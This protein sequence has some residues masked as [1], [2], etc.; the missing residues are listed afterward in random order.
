VSRILLRR[1][2]DLSPTAWVTTQTVV[3]QVIGLA[4]FAVQAPLL[5]PTAFGLFSFVMV[6]VGFCELVLN[7]GV[8]DALISIRSIEARHFEVVTTITALFSLLLGVLVFATA[9]QLADFCGQPTAYPLFRWMA[10]LPLITSFAAA[11]NAAAKREMLFRPLAIR[12]ILGWL[13]GGTVG[14]V[15]AIRGAGAWALVWQALVQRLVSVVALWI[16]VPIRLRFAW[17]PRHFVDVW[18]FAVPVILASVMGWASGQ[19]PR[20]ILGIYLGPMDLGLYSMAARLNDILVQAAIVPSTVVARVSLRHFAGN[21]QGRDERISGILRRMSVLCFPFAVGGAALLP[22]VFHVWLDPQWFGGILPSELMLLMG[23]PLL[24]VYMINAV[25]L[26][27]NEQHYDAILS[28]LQTLLIVILT[29]FFARFGLLIAVAAIA[30]RPVL[31]LPVQLAF[32]ARRCAL[33]ASVLLSSQMP[34]L[35]AA[36]LAGALVWLVRTPLEARLGSVLTFLLLALA[37]ATVYAVFL[38]M[39]SRQGAAILGRGLGLM[40]RSAT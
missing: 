11:P 4:L 9:R 40:R 18:R 7:S 26:A 17:S 6:F 29:L 3:T 34:A 13:A 5:G 27:F 22:P 16:C 23:V 1:F 36:T 30:L 2:S 33:R 35:A 14:V 21:P 37:G 39:L 20:L 19:I 28:T 24:S 38:S 32:L 25:L 15:L 10:V 8:T 31:M 12:A